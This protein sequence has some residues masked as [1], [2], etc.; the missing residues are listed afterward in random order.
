MTEFVKSM[1]AGLREKDRQNLPLSPSTPLKHENGFYVGNFEQREKFTENTCTETTR[2]NASVKTKGD[3]FS[4]K[5][6]D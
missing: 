4:F 3:G 2:E 5:V 6:G 1:A